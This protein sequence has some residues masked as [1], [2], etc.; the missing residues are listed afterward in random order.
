MFRTTE[1]F[2]AILR[3]LHTSASK[4]R[5]PEGCLGDSFWGRMNMEGSGFIQGLKKKNT[6]R[7]CRYEYLDRQ[8][9]YPTPCNEAS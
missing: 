5:C 9:I 7:K 3:L 2:D 4:R 8:F 6:D 1:I